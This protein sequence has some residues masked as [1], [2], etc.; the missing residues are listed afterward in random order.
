MDNDKLTYYDMIKIVSTV[1][2]KKIKVMIGDMEDIFD[3]RPI[4]FMFKTGDY[5][6]FS[7]TMSEQVELLVKYVVI[8]ANKGDSNKYRVM[9]IDYSKVI[10]NKNQYINIKGKKITVEDALNLKDNDLNIIPIIEDSFINTN[11]LKNN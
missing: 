5:I 2:N 11:F 10:L 9:D 7:L 8:Y 6:S 3:F 1:L 4:L